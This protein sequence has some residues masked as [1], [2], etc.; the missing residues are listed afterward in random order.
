MAALNGKWLYRS[1]RKGSDD[2]PT[3]IAIPWAPRGA[4]EVTTDGSGRVTGTLEFGPT[5]K[6]TITGNLTPAF[7]ANPANRIPAGPEGVALTGEGAGS[8][9]KIRGFF[10]PDSDHVVGTVVAE[11]GDL[12]K[13][14]DGTS[15][16]F[17]LVPSR[18]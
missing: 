1:F 18:S 2:T 10:I 14:A 11:K 3:Q 4:L 12:A 5:V 9:Y 15:G 7:P 8:V 6:L 17:V 16:P 13:Q